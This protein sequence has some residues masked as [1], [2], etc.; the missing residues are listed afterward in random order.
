MKVY[1][2]GKKE[3]PVILLLPGTCCHWKLN[4][5]KQIPLLQQT[6]YV[7]VVSYDGFDETENTIFPDMLTETKKIEQYIK[8]HFGG[9]IYAAYGCSMGGSFVSLLVQRERIHVDH[10]ILGSSDMDQSGKLAAKLK[11]VLI[12]AIMPK[13]VNK[14]KLPGFMEKRLAKKTPDERKYMEMMLDSFTANGK[15]LPFVKKESICNQFYSDLVTEVAD[16]IAVPGTVVH[17][18]YALKMGKQYEQRYRQH[19]ADPDICRHDY[20]HEEL[21]F[22]HPEKWYQEVLRVCGMAPYDPRA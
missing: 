14:G 21:F 4:F 1:E 19:F 22:C 13:L 10:A 7:A 5:E 2:F 6:F 3:N 11:T 20:Q 12:G 16:Q 8:V 15:G 17:I 9:K 18:F